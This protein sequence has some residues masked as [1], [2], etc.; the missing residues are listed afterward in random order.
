MHVYVQVTACAAWSWGQGETEEHMA[1]KTTKEAE[2]QADFEMWSALPSN[3][4][5]L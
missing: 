3:W 4:E 2:K 1:G 5:V